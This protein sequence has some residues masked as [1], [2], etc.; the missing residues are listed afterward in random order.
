MIEI[1]SN[2]LIIDG[3]SMGISQTAYPRLREMGG[4][5]KFGAKKSFGRVLDFQ[6]WP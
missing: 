5:T 6:K 4:N 3:S 1:N 2:Q